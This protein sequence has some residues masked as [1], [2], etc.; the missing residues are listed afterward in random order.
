MIVVANTSPICYLELIGHLDLLLVQFGQIIIP[1]AV[2][3]ELA[4]EGAP[5]AVRALM[6]QPPA[7]LEVRPVLAKPDTSLDRLHS[8]EREAILLAEGLGADLIVLD[9]KAAR[10]IAAQRGLNV[11]GLLGVLDEAASRDLIDLPAAIERLRQTTF[12]ASPHLLKLLLD[13]HQKL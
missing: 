13:R 10:Q 2:R 5:S 8:G 3:E 6:A 12:R 9:E 1:Q 4:S 7:W 11:T